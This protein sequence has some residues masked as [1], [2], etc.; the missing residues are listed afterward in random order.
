ME[1]AGSGSGY[2]SLALAPLEVLPLHATPDQAGLAVIDDYISFLT[3]R[4]F[5]RRFVNATGLKPN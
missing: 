5:L 2:Q 1:K 3:Q 4:T